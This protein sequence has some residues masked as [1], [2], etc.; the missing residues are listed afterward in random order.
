[1]AMTALFQRIF[2]WLFVED[3]SLLAPASSFKIVQQDDLVLV[4][5]SGSRRLVFNK[6]YRSVKDGTKLLAQFDAIESIDLCHRPDSD[7][8]PE[9]WSVSLNL[10]GWFS[11]VYIGVTCDDVDASIIAARI[12]TMTGKRVRSL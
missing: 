9:C 2:N 7:G 10:K 11:S 12:G 5:Q 4:L 6:R 1:M 3:P 8:A